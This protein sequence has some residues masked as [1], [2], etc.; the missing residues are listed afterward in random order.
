QLLKVNKDNNL[1]SLKFSDSEYSMKEPYYLGIFLVGAYQEIMGNFHNLFGNLNQVHILINSK[2]YEIEDF[3]QG[4]T[5][6]HVLNYV[7]YD[8][9]K[10]SQQIRQR[11]EQA[12]QDGRITQKESEVLWRN[13]EENLDLYTY[14]G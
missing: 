3:V 5:I 14:L 13:Y 4:D 11:T 12:V 10:L 1:F 2:G 8:T 9:N 7:Q 6:A